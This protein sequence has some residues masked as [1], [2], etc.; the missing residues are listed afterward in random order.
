MWLGLVYFDWIDRESCCG[1]NKLDFFGQVR[2]VKISIM[3]STDQMKN[4]NAHM[5]EFIKTHGGDDL[6]TF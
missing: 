4:I 5:V 2:K 6:E 3:S 1:K